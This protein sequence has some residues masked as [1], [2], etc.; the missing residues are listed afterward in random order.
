M[1]QLVLPRVYGEFEFKWQKTFGPV[2]RI[3]GLFGVNLESSK[4]PQDNTDKL[5]CTVG[6]SPDGFRSCCSSTHRQRQDFCSHSEP[7]EDGS[8]CLWGGKCVL[9]G[10]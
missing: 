2:Y 10:G 4:E 7:M 3:K 8:N 1:L 5:L 6:G 9:R